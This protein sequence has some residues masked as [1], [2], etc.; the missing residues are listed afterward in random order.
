MEVVLVDASCW[1]I[2]GCDAQQHAAKIF[3]GNGDTLSS[4][5]HYFVKES[6]PTN[7]E[8]SILI[9]L[10]QRLGLFQAFQFSLKSSW[11]F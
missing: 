8:F 1:H 3:C 9:H 4:R 2:L 10:D 7:L 11:L 5:P 6:G